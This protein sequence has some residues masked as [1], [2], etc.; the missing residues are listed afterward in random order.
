MGLQLTDAQRQDLISILS[1]VFT[2]EELEIICINNQE[3][4][5]GNLYSKIKGTTPSARF[6][7]LVNYLIQKS[8]LQCFLVVC[9]K[10]EID[11]GTKLKDFYSEILGGLFNKYNFLTLINIL[12]RVNQEKFIIKSYN[13]YLEKINQESKQS[14]DEWQVIDDLLTLMF[15]ELQKNDP[16]LD[17]SHDSCSFHLLDFGEVFLLKILPIQNIQN[18][19]DDLRDWITKNCPKVLAKDNRVTTQ[20]IN[21]IVTY[22]FFIIEPKP[23][24]DE[25]QEFFI[26]AQ[27]A[28]YRNNNT[29]EKLQE[30]PIELK[31][32]S[33]ELESY[34]EKQIPNQIDKTIREMYNHLELSGLE[35]SGLPIIELFLPINLL[36]AD[37]DIKEITDEWGNKQP[38]G[39]LYPL[40]VRSYERFFKN[41]RLKPVWKE[42]WYLLNPLINE[43]CNSQELVDK[44]KS[45]NHCLVN[46][47]YCPFPSQKKRVVFFQEILSKGSPLCL[48]TRYTKKYDDNSKYEKFI[49]IL[50]INF[51]DPNDFC[52]FH[53]IHQNIHKIRRENMIRKTDFG[54]KLGVLFDHDKIP[55]YSSPLTSPN[56]AMNV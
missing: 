18:I 30:F 2:E 4:L 56:M 26:K 32:N 53:K 37:F 7:Y 44:I 6:S 40:T 36:S 55:I 39:T 51:N 52:R 15:S 42:K 49:D 41:N 43:V 13:N 3:K 25:K 38:I 16:M 50:N 27:F 19:Q 46:L 11:Q 22:L 47:I 5:K 12:Q 54:Y 24:N 21:N 1:D 29:Q 17:E 14:F 48:W 34:L 9:L 28:Q 10:N 35:L 33:Q 20:D 23:K 31:N 45:D 8:L